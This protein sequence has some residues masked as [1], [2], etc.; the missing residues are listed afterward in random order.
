MLLADDDGAADGEALSGA[1]PN[2]GEDVNDA[3]FGGSYG[4]AELGPG[5]AGD[6]GDDVRAGR[7]DARI[8]A[9][10]DLELRGRTSG[11]ELCPVGNGGGGV[12]G[13]SDLADVEAQWRAGKRIDAR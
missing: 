7:A 11:A 12:G 4:D 1:G 6:G 8:A 9:A 3:V 2:F 13:A 5:S 10:E